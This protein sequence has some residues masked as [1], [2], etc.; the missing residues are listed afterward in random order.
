MSVFVGGGGIMNVGSGGCL[1]EYQLSLT[2][3][4]M[5]ALREESQMHPSTQQKHQKTYII[6]SAP[7]LQS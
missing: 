3:L 5:H 2:L 1:A 6:T 7:K 4:Y